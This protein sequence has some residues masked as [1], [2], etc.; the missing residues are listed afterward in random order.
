MLLAPTVQTYVEQRTEIS[1][2]QTE[3]TAEETERAELQNQLTRWEDPA[4]IKQQARNRLFLVMPGETRY[5]VMGADEFQEEQDEPPVTGSPAG[6]EDVPWVD[7]LF[8]SVKRS[9]TD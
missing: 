4:Y 1:T 3:I 2:L 9:A 5:L 6:D 7:A 8:Q